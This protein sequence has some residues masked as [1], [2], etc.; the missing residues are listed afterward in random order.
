M[1][2]KQKPNT[3]M[4]MVMDSLGVT[5]VCP[6]NHKDRAAGHSAGVARSDTDTSSKHQSKQE[7]ERSD[8]V[9]RIPVE[10]YKSEKS[11]SRRNKIEVHIT[12]GQYGWAQLQSGPIRRGYGVQIIIFKHHFG[13]W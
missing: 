11:G 10:T 12:T 5:L 4:M 13:N 7:S 9:S 3:V 2:A 1:G 6:P 8:T